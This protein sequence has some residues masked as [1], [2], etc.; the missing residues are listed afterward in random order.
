MRTK[1]HIL[2]GKESFTFDSDR[3]MVSTL[4]RYNNGDKPVC[5]VISGGSTK[6]SAE[7][8]YGTVILDNY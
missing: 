5:Y 7:S 3:K 2:G 4:H 1:P 8:C 6:P